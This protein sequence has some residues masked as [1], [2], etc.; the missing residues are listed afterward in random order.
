MQILVKLQLYFLKTQLSLKDRATHLYKRNGVA[1]PLKY[2]HRCAEFGRSALK[3]VGLN[4]G[5]PPKMESAGT[6]LSWDGRRG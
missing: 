2:V 5:E 3:D 1:Y 6:P 4:T